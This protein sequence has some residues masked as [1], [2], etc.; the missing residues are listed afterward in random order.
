MRV[1][2]SSPPPPT[3]QQR[4]STAPRPSASRRPL[5]ARTPARTAQ[6]EPRPYGGSR[7]GL[8]GSASGVGYIVRT[9]V[10]PERAKAD[11]VAMRQQREKQW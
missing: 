6:S 8:D 2:F 4:P 10:V 1:P 11:P 9:S 7:L 5:S 3:P